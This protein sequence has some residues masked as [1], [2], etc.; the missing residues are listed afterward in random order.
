MRFVNFIRIY[1]RGVIYH[2]P[3]VVLDSFHGFGAIIC[4]YEGRR[5]VTNH[6]LTTDALV[7]RSRQNEI[8]HTST[9]G[10]FR[11][12]YAII[13]PAEVRNG[14]EHTKLSLNIRNSNTRRQ[15]WLPIRRFVLSK[16]KCN[17]SFVFFIGSNLWK[18]PRGC[19]AAGARSPEERYRQYIKKSPPLR[20]LG[21]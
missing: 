20:T 4:F 14:K 13:I 9:A 19:L 12:F 5:N 3:P 11:L 16:S 10:A 21:D 2:V 6:T 15:Q 17:K 18:T 8:N 7:F 1:R